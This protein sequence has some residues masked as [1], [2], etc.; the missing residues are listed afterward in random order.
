M[1][2]EHARSGSMALLLSRYTG[3]TRVTFGAT[4]S[5]RPAELPGVEHL[6]GLF[7][8]TFPVITE[9]RSQCQV[10]EWLRELQAQNIA[11]RE[12]EH[13]PLYEIQ[14]W[15]S[16]AGQS[17]FDVLLSFQ[18]FP[19]DEALREES[20]ATGFSSVRHEHQTHYPLLVQVEQ[21]DRLRM[22]FYG[23]R[24]F[25]SS[26]AVETMAS[27]VAGLLEGLCVSAQQ[28][29]ADIVLLSPCEQALLSDWSVNARRY[30]EPEL[31]HQVIERQAKQRPDATALVFGDHGVRY[32]ELNRRANQLAHW[33]IRW[34]VRARGARGHRR[35]ALGRDGSGAVGHSEGRRSVRAVGPGVSARPPEL[36][37][38]G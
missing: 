12:H 15:A 16:R 33:L 21:A 22:R 17:L 6:I 20:R 34:G 3:E 35:G 27:R 31:I 25:F 1:I 14:S 8:N 26:H 23:R 9:L 32:E 19:L 5:G 18:N 2:F 36:H 11:S 38:G 24:Q 10:G 29:L 7:I 37:A 13:T 4:T 30:G 28:C